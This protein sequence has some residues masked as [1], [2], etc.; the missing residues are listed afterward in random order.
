[1]SIEVEIR[2]QRKQTRAYI[3]AD[4]LPVILSRSSLVR[5]PSGGYVRNTP[6]SLASQLMRLDPTAANNAPV[7]RTVDGIE[8]SPEYVLLAEW[9]ADIERGDWFY[10]SDVK[11]EIVFVDDTQRKYETRAEVANRG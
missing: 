5:D 1:M 8:I 3:A 9:N 7:R 2:L 6:T 11:Y 10:K 4:P